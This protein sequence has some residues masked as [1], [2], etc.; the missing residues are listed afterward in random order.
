[1]W[2]LDLTEE[3]FYSIKSEQ[4]L[5][6]EFANFPYKLIEL[7]QKCL[8]FP[9]SESSAPFFA[10]LTV[11]QSEGMA[12]LSFIERTSFRQ[13]TKLSLKLKLVESE[14]LRRKL[15]DLLRNY[16][17]QI[18]SLQAQLQHNQNQNV[19]P[20]N[21]NIPVNMPVNMPINISDYNTPQ[22]T[23]GVKIKTS[24][25]SPHQISAHN[26]AAGALV[27]EKDEACAHLNQLY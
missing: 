10:Q 6:V 17:E 2:Q 18:N 4:N 16:R 26:L 27:R 13:V 7:L 12:I 19:N 1:M 11:N 5:L 8:S 23:A 20:N 3:D 15:S 22:S 21:N 14:I 24:T 25:S 9:V